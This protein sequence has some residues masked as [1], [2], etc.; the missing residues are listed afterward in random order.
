MTQPFAIEWMGGVAEHHFRRARPLD[1]DIPWHSLDP[2]RYSDAALLAARRVWTDV[3]ISEYAAIAMF[4]QVV[5]AL[6][7]AR[8][9]LDLIGMTSDFVADEVKHVELAAR[10]VM[11]LGGAVPRAFDPTRLSP[12]LAPGLSP[13]QRANELALRVG[14]IGETYASGTAVPM[15]RATGHPVVRAVYETIL[16]DEAR[17]CRFGS[18][19][20]EWAEPLI[21]ERERQRLAQVA[22]QTLRH[23]ATLWQRPKPDAQVQA[24]EPNTAVS[25]AEARELGWFQHDQYQ[26]L[27]LRR[28][29]TATGVVGPGKVGP[30]I[31][32]PDRVGNE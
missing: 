14:C 15:M 10:L 21:D 22:M 27:A 25:D 12:R 4:S 24:Q 30:A 11:Q 29:D 17:H 5:S 19:Y 9:P 23:Y 18:L 7:E 3:A 6:A 20:F 2:K 31:V 8:A 28:L 13:L 32:G 26:P 16:R 1:E